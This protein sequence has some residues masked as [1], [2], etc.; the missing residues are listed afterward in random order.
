MHGVLVVADWSVDPYA[1]AAA[2]RRRAAGEPAAFTI[3]VPAWLHGL[4]WAGDPAVSV[5]CAQRQLDKLVELT[6]RAGLDVEAAGVGDP[7]VM[8]AIGDALHG[9][10]VGEV[11]LFERPRRF[12]RNPLD[13]VH[14]ARRSTGLAVRRVEARPAQAPRE[15]RG[16]ALRRRAGHC[17]PA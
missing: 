17:A 16:W 8:S 14:R 13:L 10:D 9:R 11:L 4:D 12:A 6:T 15:Q 7:D 1:V 5:P 2:L 3:V